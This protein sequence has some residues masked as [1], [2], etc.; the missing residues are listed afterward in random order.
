MNAS[1]LFKAGKLQDA[2]AAQLQAVKANPGDRNQR[3]FLFELAAFSGDL[4][5]A[6]KQLELLVYDTPDLQ[7]AVTL[8]H[9]ALDSEKLRREACS[10]A[11]T[12]EFLLE[13]PAHVQ[14][15]VKALASIRH[16]DRPAAT[17]L[18]EQANSEMP[19]PAGTL[20]GQAFA[21]ARDGDD[22]FGTVLEVFSKGK[23]YWVPLEQVAAVQLKPPG[24]PRDLLWMPAHLT[25]IDDAAGD[26]FLPT[27]YPMSHERSDEALQ[28]GRSTDWSDPEQ[29]PV[30]GV[31][32]KVF[33]FGDEDVALLDWRDL[34][35]QRAAE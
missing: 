5:R 12:P 4:D 27:L 10:G 16:N 30:R 31:G 20:N 13:P 3:L 11:K 32:A 9:F 21:G 15:R 24:T 26:V 17:T 6:R 23:Y 33:Y 25:L 28:L 1:D 18:I 19:A 34:Q 7:Q 8:Y 14:L 35:I 22:L 2:L 29:G